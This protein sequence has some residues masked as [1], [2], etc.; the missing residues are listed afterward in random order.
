[1][2]GAVNQQRSIN[3][4]SQNLLPW[5]RATFQRNFMRVHNNDTPYIA[6]NTRNVLS[7]EEVEVIQRPAR[8]PD[9]NPIE[10]IW[11]QI[12]DKDNPPTAVARLREALSQAW[13]TVTPSNHEGH[14][15]EH[16]ST[17]EGRDGRQWGSH[18]IFT[19]KSKDP[20]NYNVPWKFQFDYHLQKC[21]HMIFHQ[22]QQFPLAQVLCLFNTNVFTISFR[23]RHI[24]MLFVLV[25]HTKQ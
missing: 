25:N 4:L 19:Q 2:D 7:V 6:R 23:Q 15:T 17:T 11:E 10:H 1:M 14:C 16:A 8:S 21:P 3:I 5:A 20:I 24:V 12:R 9:L 13:G 18:P 22:N